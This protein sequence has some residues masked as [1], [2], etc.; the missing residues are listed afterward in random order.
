MSGLLIGSKNH[1]N[2]DYSLPIFSKMKDFFSQ[3]IQ[4]ISIFREHCH[5][6][7]STSFIYDSRNDTW[8]I[9]AQGLGLDICVENIQDLK[10]FYKEILIAKGDK[11]FIGD[12]EINPKD[13]IHDYPKF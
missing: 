4:N 13:I 6:D 7:G 11:V 10:T 5:T 8:I 3:K 12:R 9:L 1:W 2:S